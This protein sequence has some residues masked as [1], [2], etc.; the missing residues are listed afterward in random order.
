VIDDGAP[1]RSR[2]RAEFGTGSLGEI[3]EP[4]GD[5]GREFAALGGPAG[6]GLQRREP[7]ERA[8]VQALRTTFDRS[9]R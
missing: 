9:V 1:R 5:V 6:Q 4:L 7:G 8:C 2:L 3:H